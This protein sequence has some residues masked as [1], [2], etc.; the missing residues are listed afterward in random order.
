MKI[1]Q[2][3]SIALLL[4]ANSA[5][6]LFMPS[7]EKIVSAIIEECDTT[8]DDLISREEAAVCKENDTVSELH[9]MFEQHDMNKDGY[10]SK[11]ELDSA[12]RNYTES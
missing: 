8:R 11:V 7:P 9:D 12:I 6:V 4:S 10:V 5:C 3:V 2:I 1:V